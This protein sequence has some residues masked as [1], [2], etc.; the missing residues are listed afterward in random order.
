MLQT[1]VLSGV[2]S[3]LTAS[4][5]RI[6][7]TFTLSNTFHTVFF[8]VFG[9]PMLPKFVDQAKLELSIINAHSFLSRAFFH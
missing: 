9:F 6:L 3:F 7:V 4:H 5:Q 2:Y 1:A 8:R